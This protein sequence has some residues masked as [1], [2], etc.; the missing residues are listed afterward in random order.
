MGTNR[1]ASPTVWIMR[2]IHHGPEVNS[3]GEVGH[4]EQGEG[5]HSSPYD[6]QLAGVEA[7]EQKAHEGHDS[8]IRL[9]PPGVSA[10]PACSAV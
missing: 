1:N 10:K 3:Q 5:K 4:V 2:A 7:G 6:H 8:S 9:K